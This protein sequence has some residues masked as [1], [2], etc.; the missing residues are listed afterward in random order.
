MATEKNELGQPMAACVLVMSSDGKILVVSRKTDPRDFG[1]PGGKVDAGETPAEAAEREMFEETGLSCFGLK[2]VFKMFDGSHCTYTFCAQEV[3]GEID[4]DEG[5]VIR[6]VD[7]SVL[8]NQSRY[9][10]YN[11]KMF[12]KLF[13]EMSLGPCPECGS[14]PGCNIDCPT[15]LLAFEQDDS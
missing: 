13:T 10:N 12:A 9:A 11:R 6:W 15:C 14:E 7:P 1:L 4:T 5:G 8:I 3:S 2:Q